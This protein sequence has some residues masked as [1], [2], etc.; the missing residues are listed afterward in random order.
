MV[1]LLWMGGR[2]F[3]PR[4]FDLASDRLRVVS[5]MMHDWLFTLAQ[6]DGSGPLRV[7]AHYGRIPERHGRVID[8][9]TREE[10][11]CQV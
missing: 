9:G 5:D 10:D 3:L 6:G 2:I 1:H 8:K 11:Q 4:F 7:G